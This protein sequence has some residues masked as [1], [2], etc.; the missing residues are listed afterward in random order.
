M[1]KWPEVVLQRVLD[2]VDGIWKEKVIPECWNNKWLSL[3]H[4]VGPE[5]ATLNDLRH[6]NHL[7]T[8]RKLP[9]G[10]IVNR[11]TAVWKRSGILSE[12]QNKFRPTRSCEG[13][14]LQVLNVHEE[15][16]ELGTEFHGS[17][18]DIRH[19]TQVGIGNELGTIGCPKYSCSLHS[20]HGQEMSN[21][22]TYNT[23]TVYKACDWNECSLNSTVI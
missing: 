13:P 23:C 19:G 1:K 6:L 17:S 12:S 2:A 20:G 11:I 7:E 15:A 21:C 9:M 4:E 22:S 16:E 5:I 10:I 14:T 3:K 18:W 8:T